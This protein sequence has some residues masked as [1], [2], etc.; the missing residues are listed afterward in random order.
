VICFVLFGRNDADEGRA[1]QWVEV[2]SWKP[3]AFV[4]HN[5]L[6][7]FFFFF[8]FFYPSSF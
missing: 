7:S 2:I 8:F 1:E 4:Y 5:F 3:R 6:V